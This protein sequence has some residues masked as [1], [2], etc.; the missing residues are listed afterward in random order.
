MGSAFSKPLSYR[1]SRNVTSRKVAVTASNHV[2]EGKVVC[3]EPIIKDTAIIVAQ[4]VGM[5]AVKY[6]LDMTDSIPFASGFKNIAERFCESVQ[7]AFQNW[8]EFRELQKSVEESCTLNLHLIPFTEI[9][10]SKD[11]EY[12]KFVSDAMKELDIF[13]GAISRVSDLAERKYP[14]MN[15]LNAKSAATAM[16]AVLFNEID[17]KEIEEI[18]KM[19]NSCRNNIINYATLIGTTAA[20]RGIRKEK[21]E[22]RAAIAT[23]IPNINNLFADDIQ[24]HTEN[25]IPG[26]RAWLITEVDKFLQEPGGCQLFWLKADAGMGKSALAVRVVTMCQGAKCLLAFF[27]CRFDDTVRSNMRNLIMALAAQIAE[28][29]P[30]CREEIELAAANVTDKTTV[31][32]LM[33]LLVEE[34]LKHVTSKPS[35]NM[36]L[37]IDALDELHLQGSQQREDALELLK[38]LIKV[39]PPFIKVLLTSRPEPD[40]MKALG[41]FTPRTIEVKVQ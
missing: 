8:E 6:L 32:N 5:V 41:I 29:L 2:Q 37:V 4:V 9:K 21:E 24:R 26:S 17:R 23:K 19:I 1:Q 35:S 34:P 20:A 38:H 16:K 22:L 40:I 10:E 31:I 39:L 11:V 3:A 33:T 7:S 27:L 14:A 13:F 15:R 30:A 12:A 36:L 18:A 25:F 28:N